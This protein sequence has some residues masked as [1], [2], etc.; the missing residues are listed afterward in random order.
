MAER[1]HLDWFRGRIAKSLMIEPND[2]API[3]A[4]RDE[5]RSSIQFKA[6]L[7]GLDEVRGWSRDAQGIALEGGIIGRADDMVVVRGVNIYPTAVEAVVRAIPEIGE[8]RVVVSRRGAMT[9]LEVHIES[10]A[11]SAAARL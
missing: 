7:I 2:P 3:L 4:W 5:L 8:Y 1:V 6:D 11:D 9:D 10:A